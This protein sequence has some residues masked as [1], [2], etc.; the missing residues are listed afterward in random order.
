MSFVRDNRPRI[1]QSKNGAP[2]EALFVDAHARAVRELFFIEHPTRPKSLLATDT[3]YRAFVK[4]YDREQVWVYYPSY[5]TL[6]RSLPVELCRRVRASRN[7]NFITEEEQSRYRDARVGIA[8]LSVGSYAALALSLS[9][10]PQRMKI[11][12][13]DVLDLSNL[14]RIAGSMRE[15]GTNKAHVAARAL[16]GVDPFLEL[17]VWDQGII[18]DTLEKF[19]CDPALDVFVDEMDDLPLKIE[20]RK[21]CRRQRI[22]VIMAT[23]NGDGTVLDVERFDLEPDR[24]IFHG[25]IDENVDAAALVGEARISL[26]KKIIGAE[27]L[28]EN[29]LASLG[30]VGKSLASFPQL[31]TGA[32]VSGAAVAYGVRRIAAGGALRSGKFIISCDLD[33]KMT[34]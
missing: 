28:D 13:P 15:I 16:W 29:H 2:S 4:K 19:L 31:A 3:E 1:L 26:V 8:G 24:P 17:D 20:A 21:V 12:D 7:R 5:N 34:L 18:Q 6:V 10:G 25:A 9:G 32:L 23:D 30:E 14:N 22:P 11:A 33:K 27:H